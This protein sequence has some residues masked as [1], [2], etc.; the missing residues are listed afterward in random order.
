MPSCHNRLIA[1][2][3]STAHASFPIFVFHSSFIF[4]C[5]ILYLL[6][7]VSYF[8]VFFLFFLYHYMYV[9]CWLPIA[10]YRKAGSARLFYNKCS[11]LLSSP[12]DTSLERIY[13][14]FQNFCQGENT[15]CIRTRKKC[16]GYSITYSDLSSD[17]EPF[18][19]R[20]KMRPR[21]FQKMLYF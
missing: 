9:N 7:I 18:L 1:L 17:G 4:V 14:R 19:R 10:V 15:E 2:C 12:L 5:V 21:G 8:C 3:A 6:V 20:S 16:R 11:S 13:L